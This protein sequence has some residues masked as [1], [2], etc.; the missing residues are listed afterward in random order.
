MF[1]EHLIAKSKIKAI[2]SLEIKDLVIVHSPALI[3]QLLHY[4]TLLKCPTCP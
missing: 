2:T 4:T 1:S 3:I